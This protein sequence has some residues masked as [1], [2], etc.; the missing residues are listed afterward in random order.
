MNHTTAIIIMLLLLFGPVA[1]RTI[2]HNIEL[3][4]LGIGILATVLSD[5]PGIRI[6]RIALTQPILIA[7]AVLVAGLIFRRTRE[8]LDEVFVWMRSRVRRSILTAISIFI[9]ALM[10]SL[11][12]SII[13]ALVLVEI[14][15]MLNLHDGARERV[16]V[17]GCF[18]VGLGSALTPAG[19]PV[20]T[21]AA[22]A[23]D[24]GF[25]GLFELLSWWMIPGVMAMSLL[26]GFFARGEYYE[27]PP[28]M[29]VRETL[30]DVLLQ[31][32]KVFGFIAGLVLIGEAYASLAR[33][34]VPML[35]DTALYWANT[36]SALLDNATLLALE[37]KA[38]RPAGARNIIL[39]LLIS[40]GML[41]PGNIPNVIAAGA[42]N[43][44]SG[45]WARIAIP[46][47]L[48]ML[49]IYF[50]ALRMSALIG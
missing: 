12:T 17:A 49:G 15:G 37:V 20:S 14:A 7:I 38:V 26:A 19:G 23:L 8:Q 6:I 35:S 42:L 45:T 10:S 16:V 48:A 2:E 44:R 46:I 33:Q 25:F 43:I 18:A 31:G 28:G 47:G 40:G 22:N 21:L 41:I 9:L 4:I 13:A 1:V 36:T 32:A 29:H 24:A 11:I 5:D 3:Y 39:A 50:A 30:V 27:G 34:I